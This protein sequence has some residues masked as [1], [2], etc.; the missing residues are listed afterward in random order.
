MLAFQRFGDVMLFCYGGRGFLYVANVVRFQVKALGWKVQT[1]SAFVVDVGALVFA[2]R[3]IT[4]SAERREP[5]EERWPL[6]SDERG[7]LLGRKGCLYL[8]LVRVVFGSADATGAAR[9]S[10]G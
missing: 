7:D 6:D 10:R 9:R 2:F 4:A 3:C 8:G 1:G 5:V